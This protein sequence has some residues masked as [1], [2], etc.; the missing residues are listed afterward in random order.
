[1]RIVYL[2]ALMAAGSLAAAAYGQTTPP[3]APVLTAGAEFKGLRLDWEPVARASWYELEYRATATA[4]Y[5]QQGADLPASVTMVRFGFP[6]HL[7]DWTNARYRVAAC[8]SAGCTRSAAVSVSGL[9]RYAVGYFKASNS[10]IGS[11]FGADTDL[12]PDGLNF[13]SAA[14]GESIQTSSGAREVGA[15]YV[16]RRRADGTWFQRGRLLPVAPFRI[17][18]SNRMSV[19]ISANGNT[20]VV[21]LPQYFHE[22]FD[23]QSGEV[24]VYRFVNSSW[25]RSRLP[26][27]PRGMFGRWVAINDAGN[28]LAVATG[29]LTR[30]VLMYRLIDDTW[31]VVAT[32]TDTPGQAE[33]CDA[34]VLSRDGSTVAEPCY[35]GAPAGEGSDYVRVHSGPNWSV[36]ENLPLQLS[37]ASEEGYGHE[38]IGIS[39]DGDTIAAHVYVP[40]IPATVNGPSQVHVFRRS[41]GVF[42][43]VAELS[44]G[45]WRSTDQRRFFGWGVSVSGD[46][47]TIAVGDPWDNGLGFGPR[48]AP[49]N[50]GEAR[51]G[52]IYVYRL[53]GSW[54]LA[55]VVKPNTAG[56]DAR[57]FGHQ[58]S[59]NGNGHTLL[60]G[61]G[62]E[63]SDADGIGGNWNNTSA[64]N[65]GAVWMY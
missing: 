28:V 48:A 21:G 36:R 37:V 7:Y 42:S 61:E 9:R 59:L 31:R 51:T 49:L 30:Q 26:G 34:G 35:D 41:A 57:N 53:K 22:E 38:G 16:F 46:G 10:T 3:P 24:F 56:L 43:K 40:D 11:R 2:L 62:A 23:E 44:P 50:P 17:E 15:A 39:G 52:A 47:A 54:R 55:N 20:V 60:V 8:N 12:S 13:V 63:S 14:P 64:P 32:I 25:V 19:A 45:A 1:M 6:L 18:G 5:V 33:F 4:A 58:V 29:E 27:G 65:S